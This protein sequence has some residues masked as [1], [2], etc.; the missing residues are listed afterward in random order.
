MFRKLFS[1]MVMGI[2][3]LLSVNA[4][5]AGTFQKLYE[6]RL[7]SANM[8][9]D[10]AW[11]RTFNT[12]DGDLKVQFRRL[13]GEGD[14]KR[15][16]LTVKLGK[17]YVFKKHFPEVEGGYSLMVIKDTS[18]SRM[19]YA[20]QSVDQAYLYGYEGE[21]GKFETY[22]DSDNYLNKYNG[23]SVIAVTR[24]GNLILAFEPAY[25]SS[26]SPNQRY[27][28]FWDD[29]TLWFAYRDLGTG[30]GSVYQESQ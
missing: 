24:S 11:K 26:V 14:D 28:F 12:M 20:V 2:I 1:L 27:S 5:Q 6:V 21:T 23:D 7:S 25:V 4:C 3:M 19:F 17:N 9:S 10:Q 13:A 15:F 29:N 8:S 18:T 16:H 30:Y 22:I